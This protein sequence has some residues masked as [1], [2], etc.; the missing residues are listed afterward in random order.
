MALEKSTLVLVFAD[1][2][3]NGEGCPSTGMQQTRP[4]SCRQLEDDIDFGFLGTCKIYQTAE[5]LTIAYLYAFFLP[6]DPYEKNVFAQ[7]YA[8]NLNV[9]I[10]LRMYIKHDT[11][12]ARDLKVRKTL[13]DLKDQLDLQDFDEI[14]VHGIHCRQFESKGSYFEIL[15]KFF[16]IEHERNFSLHLKIPKKYQEIVDLTKITRKGMSYDSFNGKQITNASF[17]I[18]IKTQKLMDTRMGHRAKSF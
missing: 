8:S 15:R 13:N 9:D 4:D 7:K 14:V 6:G 3:S 1:V 5:K 2:Y 18:P 12:S 10:D 11:Q 17:D 16:I